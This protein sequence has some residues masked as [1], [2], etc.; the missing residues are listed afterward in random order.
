MPDDANAIAAPPRAA[1]RRLVDGP[2]AWVGAD[3]RKREGEWI[4]RLAPPEIAEI[5]SAVAAVRE[6][7]LDI[8]RIRC[9]D[10]P[11]PTL[12]PA[13]ERLRA[14]L[15]DGRGFVLLR[16][17]P[18]EGRPVAEGA[19]AF[20]GV[21]THFGSAR[22]QNAKGHLLGHIYDLG[23]STSDPNIRSYATAEEQR[24][25]IDR[26]D[27]VALLCLRRAKS[28]GESSIVSSMTVHNV[29]AQRRPDLLERLYRPFPT[30]W[31]G[32]VPDGKEPFYEAPVFNEYDGRLS[33]LYSRL[34]IG[35]SQRFPEARRLEPEDFEALDMFAQLAGDP[36]L[37]LDMSFMPG[38]VQIL[39]NHT[40]LHARTAYEDWPEPEKKRHLL[41]LWL[42]PPG[43]RK[44]PPVF[45]EVYGRLTVGDRGG[46]ICPGTR[47][48]APLEPG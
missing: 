25:H 9:E 7:G 30:D 40:I 13:L 19:A 6:R 21:G 5:E 39:H 23:L 38:D 31:R 2:S 41:R 8:A 44:L 46:I 43:A 15:V 36:E 3:M 4:Y 34:H 17:M 24:F 18:V 22:S 48:H 35:S 33:V 10:F 47:L 20:W 37:R 42:A 14:E 16:G 27:L 32:E 11:L 12:G 29:M 1:S 45:A 26:A 28:G